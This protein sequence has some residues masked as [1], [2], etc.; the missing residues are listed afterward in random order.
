MFLRAPDPG[1]KGYSIA[2]FETLPDPPPPGP[3]ENESGAFEGIYDVAP[4][5]F[6][7]AG[8]CA[9]SKSG[10]HRVDAAVNAAGKAAGPRNRGP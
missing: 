8:V 5:A 3:M 2:A 9:V 7:P 6:M 10:S 4:N 1:A